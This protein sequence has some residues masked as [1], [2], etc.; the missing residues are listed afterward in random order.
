MG[1]TV[2]YDCLPTVKMKENIIFTYCEVKLKILL[3]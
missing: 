1:S 2:N 3:L